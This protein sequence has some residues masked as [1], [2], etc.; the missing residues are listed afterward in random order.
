M[1]SVNRTVVISPVITIGPTGDGYTR[2]N[3]EGCEGESRE[4]AQ[5]RIRKR[6]ISLNGLLKNA[7]E[8]AVYEVQRIG[9][10]QYK[11]HI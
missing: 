8:L 6:E 11:E 3:I 1:V 2:G 4:Q 10:R 7:N 5:L 9:C